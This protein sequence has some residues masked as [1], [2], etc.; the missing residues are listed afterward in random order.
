[1]SNDE[2]DPKVD[3]ENEAPDLP[4]NDTPPLSETETLKSELEASKKEYLYLRA[5]FDNFRKQSIKERS[6][7][8]KFGGEYIARDL[9]NALDVFEKALEMEV[10]SENFQSFLDGVKLTEKELKAVF[11]KHGINEIDCKHKPFNPEQ[12]EALS[13]VPS[14]DLEEGSVYDVMRKGYLYHDKVLRHA[15]VVIATKPASSEN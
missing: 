11:T 12:A 3:I 8:M 1:M 2:K 13:Q 9:L 6:D 7:L 15:Q 10:T 14:P 4:E 5:E